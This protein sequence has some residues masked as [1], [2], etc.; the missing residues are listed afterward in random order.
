MFGEIKSAINSSPI[1][2]E[3]IPNKCILDTEIKI[4]PEWFIK[5]IST[6]ESVDKREYGSTKFQGFHSPNLFIVMDEA[7]GVDASIH[8]GVENLATGNNNKIL[9]IGNP[10][11]P[12]GHF[13]NNCQNWHNIH[14]SAFSHPNVKQGKEIIPGCVTKEWVEERFIDWGENSPLFISK[15]LGKFPQEGEDTVIP[16]NWIENAVKINPEVNDFNILG[17]DPARFGDDE[18]VFY[19]I[20]NNIAFLKGVYLK[21]DTMATAGRIV[22]WCEREVFNIVTGDPIGIGSGIFDRIN[23]LNN[24]Y[25][26]RQ[27]GKS[28]PIKEINFAEKSLESKYFNLRAEV[29]GYLAEKLRP[30]G[31]HQIKIPDDSK[32]QSQLASLKYQ[33]TSRGQLKLESKEDMKKRGLKSPDRADAL[34]I[35]VYGFKYLL[36]PKRL[37]EYEKKEDEEMMEL[38]KPKRTVSNLINKL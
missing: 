24:S 31:Q 11:S 20:Q 3:L 5:G 29:Y 15:V 6:T 12:T 14:I 34:A 17:F 33:F 7:P 28:I 30:D 21:Q 19:Q 25:E 23:E 18:T 10:T 8:I 32:L 36:Q 22:N 38:R 26:Y 16:L 13:Y 1:L 27:L 37:V 2:S 4:A 9:E 35:A